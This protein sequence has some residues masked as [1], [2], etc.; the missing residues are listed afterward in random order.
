MLDEFCDEVF[1]QV[2]SNFNSQSKSDEQNSL[3]Y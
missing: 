1:T 2:L 3:Y